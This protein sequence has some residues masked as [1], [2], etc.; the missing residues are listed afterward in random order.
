MTSMTQSFSTHGASCSNRR[1][2]AAAFAFL[3]AGR[4]GASSDRPRLQARLG[5]VSGSY[6]V[7]Q[8]LRLLNNVILARLLGPSILGLMALVN[9][10]RTGVELL[11]DVGIMQ[12]IISSPRGEDPVFYDTAWTLQALRGLVLAIIGLTLSVPLARFFHFPQ[13]AVILPVASL[14]F[15]FTGFDSTA[16]PLVQKQLHVA[17]LSVFDIGL[18]VRYCPHPNIAFGVEGGF[19]G[20]YVD[21]GFFLYQHESGRRIL[22]LTQGVF[23]SGRIYRKSGNENVLV[24]EISSTRTFSLPDFR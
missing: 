10:I 22:E 15:V 21:P 6:G 24:Y 9:S 11:S 14:F 12:N 4:R 20:F 8:L 19:N 1:L 13:L 5:W 18:G 23:E 2:R 3:P 17:R 16:R 7:V